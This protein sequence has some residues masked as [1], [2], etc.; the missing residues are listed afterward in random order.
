MPMI[1][2]ISSHYKSLGFLWQSDYD[3]YNLI[4]IVPLLWHTSDKIA[5]VIESLS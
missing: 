1:G 2:K 5:I 4:F 3:N